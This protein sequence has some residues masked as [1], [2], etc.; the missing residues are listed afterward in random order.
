MLYQSWA[1]Q[2]TISSMQKSP[3]NSLLLS[4][5]GFM[6]ENQSDLFMCR[7]GV[8]LCSI[9]CLHQ[10][11]FQWTLV[12]SFVIIDTLLVVLCQGWWHDQRKSTPVIWAECME[13]KH[14][15]W[16]KRYFLLGPWILIFSE[17]SQI[18]VFSLN[19]P[20]KNGILTI[21]VV[22]AGLRSWVNAF[23]LIDDQTW[24]S[25]FG[26]PW[27]WQI[28]AMHWKLMALFEDALPDRG[29]SR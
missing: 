3:A 13:R 20:P 11:L 24:S 17:C 27:V 25:L 5:I 1:A 8:F 19:N 16:G 14:Y 4:V 12:H 28:V 21:S 10:S 23:V 22:E 29:S 9:L 2:K 7:S 18:A 6:T 15:F 26:F